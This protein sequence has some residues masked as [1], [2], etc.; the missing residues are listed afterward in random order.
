MGQRA[1]PWWDLEAIK[2]LEPLLTRDMKVFEWGSGRSTQWFADR[3]NSIVSVE[4]QQKWFDVVTEYLKGR[5][6]AKLLL[7]DRYQDD[8]VKA[9][10]SFKDET[11]D[12]VA[13]DGRRRVECCREAISKIKVGG[14]LLFDDIQ[15]G[16]Y[17]ASWALFRSWPN[18]EFGWKK[19]MTGIYQK[20]PKGI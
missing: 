10:S 9:I 12:L 15:R 14:Y 18:R 4:Y 3:V 1:L 5:S 16:R 13:I 11:F 2:Y 8:Y 20:C 17:K 6:N 7:L 19:K